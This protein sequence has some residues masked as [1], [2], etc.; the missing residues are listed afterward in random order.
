MRAALLTF[1]AA[2]LALAGCSPQAPSSD[3]ARFDWFEYS[4]GDPVHAGALGENEAFNPVLA[5][6][7]PDPSNTRAG[8]DY[9]LVT[10]TFAYYPGLPV[11]HSRDLVNWTQIGNAIAKGGTTLLIAP[12]FGNSKGEFKL[13]QLMSALDETRA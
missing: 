12:R 6:F 11:F 4:G 8:E 2:G 13:L 3:V 5:G 10:S 7:Y 9:Y 1:T